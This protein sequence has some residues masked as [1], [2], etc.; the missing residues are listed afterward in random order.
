MQHNNALATLNDI[1]AM[2]SLEASWSYR[3]LPPNALSETG[4][5]FVPLGPEGLAKILADNDSYI[6]T[7]KDSTRLCGMV[8]ACGAKLALEMWPSLSAN[9]AAGDPIWAESFLYVKTVAILPEV[10]GTG[11]GKGLLSELRRIA[12]GTGKGAIL[13]VIAVEPSNSRS[14]ALFRNTL[15]S[16]EIG[17]HF[18]SEKGILWGLFK[19]PPLN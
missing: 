9:Y 15:L 3:V 1:P 10:T 13:A 14:L 16:K 8:V 6:L 12:A 7:C 19:S 5:L 2:A 17:R 4:A 18:D 11:L